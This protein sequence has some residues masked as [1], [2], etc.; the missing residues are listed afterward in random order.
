MKIKRILYATDV[1]K[2]DFSEL[3][4]LM[5]L[6][7]LGLEEIIFLNP[8]GAED[9]EKR[10][11]GYGLKSKTLAGEGQ[12]LPKILDVARQEATSMIAVSL[13]RGTRKVFRGSVIKNLLRSSPVPVIVFSESAQVSG[14][15]EKGVFRHVVYATD[16]SPVSETVL[17]YLLNFKE[18]IEMLEIVNVIMKRLSV[19]DMRNLKK[20]LVETRQIFLDEGIDAESHVY[21][22]N[23]SEEIMLAARDYG[24]TSIVMGTSCKSPFQEVF[25]R[26]YSYRIAEEAVVPTLFIRE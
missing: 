10:V 12:V 9:W 2:P 4:S 6:R 18:I 19:R 20:K 7:K 5:V 14:S 21:A 3:E 8:S 1:E 16:W 26:S 23:P 24:A 11:V 13:N 15:V 25:S 22:G 17:K